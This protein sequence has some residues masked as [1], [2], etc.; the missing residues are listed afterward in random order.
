[1]QKIHPAEELAEILAQIE[2]LEDRKWELQRDFLA[3]RSP[4]K[5]PRHSVQIQEDHARVFD[6]TRLPPAILSNPRFY[7]DRV[8]TEVTVVA[9]DPQGV[10]PGFAAPWAQDLDLVEPYH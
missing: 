3:G 9:S 8:T 5:G 4:H 1:M 7:A 2:T 10:L 6:K